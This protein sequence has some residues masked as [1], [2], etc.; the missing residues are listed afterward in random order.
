MGLIKKEVTV[1][2]ILNYS[3][4]FNILILN[5]SSLIGQDSTATDKW[6]LKKR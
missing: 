1:R 4:I 2:L 3:L 5:K 6:S